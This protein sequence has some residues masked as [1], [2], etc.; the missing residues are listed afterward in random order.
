MAVETENSSANQHVKRRLVAREVESCLSGLI[1]DCLRNDT[2]PPED[3]ENYFLT[4]ADLLELGSTEEEA[5]H[6]AGYPKE[7]YE[8]WTV[9]PW[10][11]E[12][13]LAKGEVVYKGG[14]FHLWGRQCSGQAILL[15][16]VISEIA[17]GL[18]ILEGQ[19]NHEAWLS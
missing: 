19:A 1:C 8:W 9:S 10:F 3:V 15:D 7:V 12:K 13:L 5:D 16:S 6:D 14:S 2:I 17:K 18:E 4:R 11:Y